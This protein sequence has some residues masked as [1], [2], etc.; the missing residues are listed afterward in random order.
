MKRVSRPEAPQARL[1]LPVADNCPPVVLQPSPALPKAPATEPDSAL[2]SPF[3]R[4]LAYAKPDS[5]P[6]IVTRSGPNLKLT[7]SGVQITPSQLAE[8]LRRLPA[9]RRLDGATRVGSRTATLAYDGKL[10]RGRLAP[11]SEDGLVLVWTEPGSELSELEGPAAGK[12]F[13][14]EGDCLGRLVLEATGQRA[15]A[16]IY[17]SPEQR[18]PGFVLLC[19]GEVVVAKGWLDTLER[20]EEARFCQ[21]VVEGDLPWELG[22][23]AALL[24][25]FQKLARLAAQKSKELLETVA[26]A[27]NKAAVPLLK[28]VVT[29]LNETVVT[30]PEHGAL[31]GSLLDSPKFLAL[32]EARRDRLPPLVTVR[33]VLEQVHFA[34]GRRRVADLRETLGIPNVRFEEILRQMDQVLRKDEAVCL[35]R[36]LD[37]EW[38]L[39]HHD[40]LIRIFALNL[41]AEADV[42]VVSATTLDGHQRRVDVPISLEPK[43]RRVV[44][45]L[46]RYGRLSE[47]ELSQLVGT[48]RVGG[49]LEKLVG[50]LEAEGSFL[51]RVTGSSDDGRVYE[52]A[53]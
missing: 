51:L 30:P 18:A 33:Q 32:A 47:R 49:L 48:R 50:R 16:R 10:R 42:G 20:P 1:S 14:P 21:V 19:H 28:D 27:L 39:L 12:T 46:L 7:W 13:Q 25:R 4:L 6:Y 53:G 17:R 26:P 37:G 5:P 44:E 36:S 35:S 3:R 41:Q 15:V 23:P 22:I 52:L 45:A 2:A 38:L 29:P 8:L 31:I 9:A 40:V 11:P 34:G 43:E 24:G